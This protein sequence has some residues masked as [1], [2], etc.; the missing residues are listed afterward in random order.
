MYCHHL[1]ADHQQVPTLSHSVS[2]QAADDDDD[3]AE[4]DNDDCHP[5]VVTY[6]RIESA[7][8]SEVNEGKGE[9][10]EVGNREEKP[11]NDAVFQEESQAM[12]AQEE[13]QTGAS[14]QQERVIPQS[15]PQACTEM[16]TGVFLQSLIV[17]ETLT[18]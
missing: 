2:V 14:M 18:F 12:A 1:A 9:S 8:V 7:R 15:S 17:Y 13:T 3:D 6:G 16:V 5:N 11:L 4:D 10:Y